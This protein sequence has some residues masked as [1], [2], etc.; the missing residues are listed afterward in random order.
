MDE[1]AGVS[2]TTLRRQQFVLAQGTG[3]ITVLASVISMCIER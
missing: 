1:A 3:Q 2:W